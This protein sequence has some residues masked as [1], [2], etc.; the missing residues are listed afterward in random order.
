REGGGT[1][2]RVG[3]RSPVV[4]G[5]RD[6]AHAVRHR[7][8]DGVAQAAVAGTAQG[9]V[10]HAGALGDRVGDA[11]DDRGVRARPGAVEHPHREDAGPR[12]DAGDADVVAGALRDGAGDVRPVP[13]AVGRVAVVV[14]EV[15]AGHRVQVLVG[16]D[17][18]VD[19]GHG[20]A[21]A[22]RTGAV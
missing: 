3:D 21:G 16:G 6:H 19:D 8:G 1:G 2:G 5:R 17:A 14:D 18:A 20:H 9:E 15:V 13:V 4:A 10:D 11:L 12:G 7:V 22:G